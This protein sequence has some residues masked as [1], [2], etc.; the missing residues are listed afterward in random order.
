MKER[1][2][3]FSAPMVR[4]ILEGR[5]TMTRREANNTPD[6]IY[7]ITDNSIMVIHNKEID[8]DHEG[9]C[10]IEADPC[11]P[12]R[13][14]YGWGGRE[15][16]FSHQ[17]QRLWKK[18][19][20]GLV[21]AFW[22]RIEEGLS[23]D[24]HVSREQES[25]EECPPIDLYCFPRITGKE[26]ASGE[27]SRRKSSEQ[28][29]LESFMGNAGR[30]LERPENSWNSLDWGKAL[31]LKAHE[32]RE[33]AFALGNSS[34][35]VLSTGGGKGSRDESIGYLEYCKFQIGMNLWVREKYRID[36]LGGF[37]RCDYDKRESDDTFGIEYAADH[38]VLNRNFHNKRCNSHPD[39]P[40]DIILRLSDSGP[41]SPGH[42]PSI[43]MPRWASRITLE[44]TNIRVERLNSISTADVFA[45]G[46]EV[47]QEDDDGTTW[48]AFSKAQSRFM[49]LWESINGPGSWEA[50][51]W[52]WV[53]EF[54]RVT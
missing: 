32:R 15:Y 17:I 40:Y 28:Q 46:M 4:A 23:N 14:L 27:A 19:V 30:K 39:I 21:C 7:R 54:K 36:F 51:P 24:F 12:E 6:L 22:L 50:N 45:E 10:P 44:I 25:N 35:I 41:E 33:R 49:D 5:K 16:L 20:R 3:L 53:V 38:E 13:R 42:R 18:G 26:H 9:W 2:I 43:H 37:H 1:P 48:G 11:F 31:G 34:R 47:H 52:V 29:T 8:H